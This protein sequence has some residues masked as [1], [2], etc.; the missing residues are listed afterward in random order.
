VQACADETVHGR[1][2]WYLPALNELK[3]V[4]YE[5][6]YDGTPNDNSPNPVIS[7]F[8]S[9]NYWSS[10]ESN[11]DSYR[12]A[13]RVRFDNGDTGRQDKENN[14]NV[15]CARLDAGYACGASPIGTVCAD[16]SVYAGLSP[17]GSVPM[18]I[19]RC[20]LGQSWD[21]A[22][23]SGVRTQPDWNDGMDQLSNF[24]DIWLVDE[25][26][27]GMNAVA[28]GAYN[29]SL[30]TTTDSEEL[31]TGLQPHPAA[32]GCDSL[33][34]H[35]KTDWYLPARDELLEIYEKL[36]DGT[37]NDNSPDPVADGFG[38]ASYW[39][40]TQGDTNNA[41]DVNFTDGSHNWNADKD[42]GRRI[43]CARKD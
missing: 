37:P 16:G 14:Y 5:N 8:V 20:D 31:T 28:T 4:I 18:F 32:E 12:R 26:N 30:L 29:T 35:G 17:D 15:R 39:S 1:T 23:C 21:G 40:S 27:G 33:N 2:D 43:R 3:N 10:S 7:G 22:A 19:P 9:E 36:Y 34:I 38:M 25:D 6:L 13:E 42:W 11:W 41:F 24:I